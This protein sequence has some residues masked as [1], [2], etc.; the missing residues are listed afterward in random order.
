MTNFKNISD[1]ELY[2]K[3]IMYGRQALQARRK[4]IGL[5]PEVFKRK[6]FT[7]KGFDSVYE[8]AARLAGIS[9]DQVNKI[10]QLERK[11]QDKP[12][13]HSALVEGNISVNKLVRIA[14]IS[15]QSNQSELVK[16]A[17]TLSS[18]A[19][20]VYVRDV[21]NKEPNG[22]N[23]PLFELNSVHVHRLKLDENIESELVE[24]QEKG[25]DV[26]AFLRK[27]LDQRKQQIEEQKEQLSKNIIGMPT[28]R[29][30]PAKIKKI[31]I[32][33]HGSR[34]SRLVA[35]NQCKH[36][37]EHLHHT[38]RFSQSR[39]HDPQFLKPLCKAHHELE[40]AD[41]EDYRKYRRQTGGRQPGSV[42]F[43]V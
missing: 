32:E 16:K 27:C 23:M 35:G 6:L 17:E 10:L 14:S 7:K 42:I 12:I 19:L 15:T 36:P 22:F 1:K 18:R 43:R 25:I 4:F 41:E 38:K 30:I 40:H 11:Y 31:I 33:E 24:M 13:L 34:C 26:N 8:F 37:A 29:Y 21:K 5:L 9:H 2:R 39:A 28:S 3:C 20:E